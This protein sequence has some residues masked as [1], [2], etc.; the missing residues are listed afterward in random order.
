[1]AQQVKAFA[2]K[3]K[4]LSSSFRTH[5]VEGENNHKLFSDLYMHTTASMRLHMH[6]Y[7]HKISKYINVTFKYFKKNWSQ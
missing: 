4:D 3:P 2:A 5:M 6:P 1:M 7:M